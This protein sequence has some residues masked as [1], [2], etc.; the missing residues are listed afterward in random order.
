MVVIALALVMAL[1]GL[2]PLLVIPG[3]LILFREVFVSGLREFLGAAAGRLQVTRLAKWKTTA[4]MVAITLLLLGLGLA[5]AQFWDARTMTGG[6]HA[7]RM[8][9]GP[10]DWNVTWRLAQAGWLANMAGIGLFWVA[11]ALTLITGWDY[12][13]KA[14][15]L[16]KEGA[17]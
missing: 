7:A 12:F 6:E 9:Q 1:S 14:L 15:P 2:D 5:E 16:L 10:A 3:T 17:E 11:A 8:A 4:Q 13:R